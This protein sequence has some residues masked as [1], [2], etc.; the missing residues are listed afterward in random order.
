MC[1]TPFSYS[2]WDALGQVQ[3]KPI[4]RLVVDGWVKTVVSDLSCKTY[5]QSPVRWKYP[6]TNTTNYIPDV[7]IWILIINNI[8]VDIIVNVW[9][10]FG[11]TVPWQVAHGLLK[12]LL[13]T[14]LHIYMV[15]QPVFFLHRSDCRCMTTHCNCSNGTRE[16]SFNAMRHQ[17]ELIP[18]GNVKW[19]NCLNARLLNCPAE[20]RP[21]NNLTVNKRNQS[22][23]F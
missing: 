12:A 10:A 21:S 19:I 18:A 3:S 5:P 8:K 23:P 22:S 16:G 2:M 17:C 6:F 7:V 13:Y 1:Q 4:P 20:Q 15:K 9:S 11:V 14:Q